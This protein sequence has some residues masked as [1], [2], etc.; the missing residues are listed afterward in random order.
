MFLRVADGKRLQLLLRGQ[1]VVPPIQRLAL[2]PAH[3]CDTGL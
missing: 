3:R 2:G 1:T